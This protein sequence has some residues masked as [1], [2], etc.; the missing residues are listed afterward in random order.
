MKKQSKIQ[1]LPIGLSLIFLF[2]PNIAVIDV[3]PDF[4]GYI[5][6]SLALIKLSDINETIA[7]AASLFNK[8]ILIDAAKIFAI[9]W[10]FWIYGQH[11]ELCRGCRSFLQ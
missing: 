10:I 8:M 4:I 11:Q 5:L 7:E 9:V 1:F 3:L 6:I 2:N